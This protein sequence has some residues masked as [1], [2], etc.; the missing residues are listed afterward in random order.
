MIKETIT[1]TKDNFINLHKNQNN[2]Y[3]IT[4]FYGDEIEGKSWCPDCVN[5][6]EKII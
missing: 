1:A 4:L 6:K 3:L 2:N 5:S